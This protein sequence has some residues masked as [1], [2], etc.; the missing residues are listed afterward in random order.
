MYGIK[1]AHVCGFPVEVINEAKE[2]YQRLV[3][4]NN[5]AV[6]VTGDKESYWERKQ[7]LVHQLLAI[8]NADLDQPRT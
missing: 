4:E 3:S 7:Q 2:L 1:T 6:A 8:V 5:E